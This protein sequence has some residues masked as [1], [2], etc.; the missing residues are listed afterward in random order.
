MAQTAENVYRD[1]TTAGV[2]SS[3]EHK[4]KKA[5][6]RELLTGYE[7]AINGFQAGGGIVFQTKAAMTLTYAANQMAW[8]IGDSTVANNGVYQKQGASGAGSWLRVADL[9]YSFIRANNAGAGAANA[10]VATSS[11]PLPSAAYGAIILMNVFAANTGAVTVAINGAT[12]KPLVTNSGN[13][14]AAGYLTAGMLVAF[15]DAGA[16]YRLLSDVASAAIQAAAEA[17]EA[18]AAASA[19]EAAG[20]AALALSNWVV[21]TFVGD[22]T[23]DPLVLTVNPGSVNNC[24]ITVEGEGPQP[25]HIFSLDGLNLS[26][27]SGSVWPDG[28]TIEVAY[29]TA[30]E[31]GVPSD[32]SV[33]RAKLG[34]DAVGPNELDEE[35][36]NATHL[37]AAAAGAMRTKLGLG[38]GD[39]PDFAGLTISGQPIGSGVCFKAHKNNVNQTAIVTGTATKISFGSES[40]DIGNYYDTATSR[41]T[42]PA[43]KYRLSATLLTAS[44]MVDQSA[45]AVMIYQNGARI[46]RAYLVASGTT[47]ISPSI[48]T[49]V[50]AD[51]TDYF[52]VFFEAFGTGDKAINGEATST[53]FCGEAI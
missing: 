48:T 24:V 11:I 13:A 12:G 45:A 32:G 3:G 2:P 28:K 30:I 14:L 33:T 41:F 44:G 1:F 16:N 10:I 5:E 40:F 8:V 53:W 7:A 23:A 4:V 20:Y 27:P 43:G 21:D 47:N 6:I 37:D 29:G 26:P 38:T 39:T 18:A 50:S 17:A 49:I 52:E 31:V 22:G 51:G 46:A 19:A 42:P 9:P 34:P 25:R 35:T 15:V 36:V